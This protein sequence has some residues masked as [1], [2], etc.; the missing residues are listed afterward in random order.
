MTDRPYITYPRPNKPCAKGE[1]P[2]T[3]FITEPGRVSFGANDFSPG[4]FRALHGHHTWELVI[5]DGGSDG[6]GYI[7]FDGRWW[8][9]DPGAAV[10]VPKGHPHAWSSGNTKGFRMLWVYGGAR[11]E[12]GRIWYVNPEEGKAITP[13]EEINA[14]V[15]TPEAANA[16]PPGSGPI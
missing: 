6:P 8:R 7:N 4:L 5:V 9:V 15:W 2:G 1:V 14:P 3:V 16:I 12:A 10:F 11:E 13:E